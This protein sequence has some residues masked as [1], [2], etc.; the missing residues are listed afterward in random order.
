MFEG[1]DTSLGSLYLLRI[2]ERQNELRIEI[3]NDPDLTLKDDFPK[4]NFAQTFKD[5][6]LFKKK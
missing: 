5:S 2:F 4:L 1:Y 6:R 3:H